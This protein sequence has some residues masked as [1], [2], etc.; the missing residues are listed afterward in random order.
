MNDNNEKIAIIHAKIIF[1]CTIELAAFA[2][3]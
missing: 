3:N 2:K 1:F